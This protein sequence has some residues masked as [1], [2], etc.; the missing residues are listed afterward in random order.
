MKKRICNLLACVVALWAFSA[1]DLSAQMIA[2]RTDAVKDLMLTPSL[3][4]DFVVGEKYTLGAEVAFNHNP[5][6]IKMQMTS[7]T[8]EFR[9]WYNGRPFTRQYIGI[10]ANMTGYNLAWNNIH[11]GDAIGVGI[12]FGHVITLT[13]RWS[14]DF[15]GSLGIIGY[16]EK[17]YYKNDYFTDYGERPNARGYVLLPIKLGVSA[18]YVLR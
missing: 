6:G 3:G 12:S 2:L 9:Y 18:I 13:Q 16:R 11:Q 7:V 8:P 17:Y 4:L 5:W 14:I 10:V 15:A 1:Q